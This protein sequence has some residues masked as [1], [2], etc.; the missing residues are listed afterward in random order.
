MKKPVIFLDLDGTAVNLTQKIIDIHN[1]RFGMRCTLDDVQFEL[2]T[3]ETY[4]YGPNETVCMIGDYLV[5]DGIFED[6][7]F[8]PGAERAIQRLMELGD[9]LV[10]TAPS[11]NPNS[12]A[13][14]LRWIK[15]RTG[16]DRKK[17]I[18][19]KEK[20]HLRG[21]AFFEDWPENLRAIR[22]ENP[23]AFIGTIEYPYNATIPSINSIAP[24]YK[25]TE[26]AWKKLIEDFE[27]WLDDRNVQ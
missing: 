8:L 25:D 13:E 17:V 22:Q 19:A 20:F 9:L 14:K 12:A 27:Q 4:L 2:P 15:K 10:L 16:I 7:E 11:K 23:D 18:L 6:L 21:A 5:N 24:D 3:G 1:Q 26:R